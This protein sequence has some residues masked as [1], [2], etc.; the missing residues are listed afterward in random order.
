MEVRWV[1]SE[2]EG[3]W[4]LEARSWVGSVP[5]VKWVGREGEEQGWGSRVFK[6]DWSLRSRV[7]LGLLGLV[8]DI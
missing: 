2:G 7:N 1:G 5:E 3:G 8:G 4:E 6:A